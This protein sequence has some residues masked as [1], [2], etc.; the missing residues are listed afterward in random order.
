[1]RSFRLLLSRL[2]GRLRVRLRK[3]VSLLLERFAQVDK[4]DRHESTATERR[5]VRGHHSVSCPLEHV[6]VF[7]G[8]V[9]I[10]DHFQ[11]IV[12]RSDSHWFV[13]NSATVQDE[14]FVLDQRVDVLGPAEVEGHSTF[15]IV[16]HGVPDQVASTCLCSF[17]LSPPRNSGVVR[18]HGVFQLIIAR[19][20]FVPRISR[21]HFGRIRDKEHDRFMS[22][23]KEERLLVVGIHRLLLTPSRRRWVAGSRLR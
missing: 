17:D 11:F 15:G 1:M 2:R 4:R 21:F 3:L 9:R 10:G 5:P 23:S 18:F 20:K 13:C 14:I 22:Q 12:A 19:G 8:S 7:L 16:I 6:P